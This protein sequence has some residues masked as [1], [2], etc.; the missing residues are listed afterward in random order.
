MQYTFNAKE[1]KGAEIP[2]VIH[3]DGTSRIQTVTQ[4]DGGIYWNLIDEFE[5]RTGVPMVL[6]TSF[7]TKKGEPIVESPL[8]AIR[9]FLEV[10]N[11]EVGR[12]KVLVLGDF[13]VTRKSTHES[14]LDKEAVL[15]PLVGGVI[16][17][18]VGS[19][20]EIVRVEVQ[21][22]AGVWVQLFDRLQ[23]DILN[24]IDGS[25]NCG[26]IWEVLNLEEVSD[27]DEGEGD[28]GEEEIITFKEVSDRMLNL[29][30]LELIENDYK[31]EK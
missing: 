15:A 22:L 6:N 29:I 5:K 12:N 27:E 21:G 30:E 7:N 19:G 26:D 14:L 1:G 28:G 8:D 31:R 13:Y 9:S 16:S 2:A 11:D 4:A 24:K 17:R 20:E 25:V 18:T 3:V 23:L 10:E